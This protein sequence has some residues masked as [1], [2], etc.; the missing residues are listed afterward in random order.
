MFSLLSTSKSPPAELEVLR[1]L[2]PRWG[3][4]RNR[5]EAIAAAEATKNKKQGEFRDLPDFDYH[6]IAQ[7]I[8]TVSASSHASSQLIWHSPS[9][10][11]CLLIEHC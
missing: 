11:V 10:R 9:F 5:L 1:L 4:L 6:P 2:A 3:S 8:Q 7:R